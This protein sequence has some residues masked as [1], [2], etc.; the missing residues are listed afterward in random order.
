MEESEAGQLKVELKH[1]KALSEGRA[2]KQRAMVELFAE[3]R[4]ANRKS[5]D[6]TK[7]AAKCNAEGGQLPEQTAIVG[8][9]LGGSAKT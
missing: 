4:G 5:Y 2:K 1:Q 8:R 7:Q 3:M 6:F 9:L